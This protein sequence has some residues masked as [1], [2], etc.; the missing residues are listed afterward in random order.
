MPKTE[1][2]GD[3]DAEEWSIPV[4]WK[5]DPAIKAKRRNKGNA[6]VLVCIMVWMRDFATISFSL[7]ADYHWE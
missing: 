7:L 2:S 5:E 3:D 6:V 4:N 1:T